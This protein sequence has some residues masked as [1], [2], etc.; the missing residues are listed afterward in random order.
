MSDRGVA[1]VGSKVA[2]GRAARLR[3]PAIDRGSAQVAG[4][5]SSAAGRQQQRQLAPAGSTAH[6]EDLD[7]L[8]LAAPLELKALRGTEVGCG[9]Q[10]AGQPPVK[11]YQPASRPATTASQ[12]SRHHS[13]APQPHLELR[14]AAVEVEDGVPLLDQLPL[15]FGSRQDHGLRRR[16]AQGGQAPRLA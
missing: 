5:P 9:G 2:P 16:G 7:E 15:L 14:Q 4:A 3:R 11:Q 13:Q 12:Q 8:Q 10:P 6:L 1:R